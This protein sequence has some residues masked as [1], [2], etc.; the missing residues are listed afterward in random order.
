MLEQTVLS[1]Q[2]LEDIKQMADDG[3]IIP[4]YY[5]FMTKTWLRSA[6]KKYVCQ[7]IQLFLPG[8]IVIDIFFSD[9]EISP[10]ALKRMLK[11][12]TGVQDIRKKVQFDIFATIIVKR[13]LDSRVFSIFLDIESQ[14]RDRTDLVSRQDHYASVMMGLAFRRGGEYLDLNDRLCA[15]SLVFCVRNIKYFA[16]PKI[17]DDP[18]RVVHDL[19]GSHYQQNP[20][21]FTG[22]YLSKFVELNKLCCKPE[23][24]RIVEGSLVL[25]A[26]CSAIGGLDKM[27]GA[28]VEKLIQTGGDIVAEQVGLVADF[29][30]SHHFRNVREALLSEEAMHKAE[31]REVE[32]KS[33]KRGEKKGEKKGEKRGKEKVAKNLLSAGAEV[34]FV[35]KMTGISKEKISKMSQEM[36]SSQDI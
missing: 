16:D 1:H 17:C 2:S 28:E 25:G 4:L 36:K 34:A 22:M 27:S 14:S 18:C 12:G 3:L 29:S 8:H 11:D 9:R 35:S 6:H 32:S 33:L 7:F 26:V 15:L 19:G 20:N 31:L 10:N 23:K 5:D 30:R 21:V 13:L 24:D